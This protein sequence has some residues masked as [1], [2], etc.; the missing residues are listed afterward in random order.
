MSN[1]TVTVQRLYKLLNTMEMMS[2]QNNKV[3]L[4]D[5]AR[6]LGCGFIQLHIDLKLLIELNQLPLSLMMAFNLHHTQYVK[7]VNKTNGPGYK[8]VRY[9]HWK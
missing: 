2:A 3:N 4:E 7:R 6:K 1:K 5:L 9:F 8:A